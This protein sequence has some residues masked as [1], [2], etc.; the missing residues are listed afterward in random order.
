MFRKNATDLKGSGA[1]FDKAVKLFKQYDS[2]VTYTKQPMRINFPSG[3]S[4]F[5]TGLDGQSGMDSIQ[6]IEIT[7]AMVDEATHLTEEEVWWIIS[8]LRTNAKGIEPNIW[9]TCNPDIDSFLFKW[10]GWYLYP[11]GTLIGDELVEGRPDP[12]KNCKVRW[13]LTGVDGA[14]IWGDSKE[15]FYNNYPELTSPDTDLQPETFTFIG[16]SCKDNPLMLKANPK[17]ESNLL[18]LPR[19]KRERLYYGKQIA[20]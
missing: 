15:Y 6:G 20:A 18:K 3:A 11:E 2:M 7:A 14:M 12:D 9:L 8:R 19:V 10:V 13:F 1:L 4:I 16:A 5:F 17:Y